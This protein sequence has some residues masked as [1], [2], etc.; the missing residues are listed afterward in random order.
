MVTTTTTTTAAF[1]TPVYGCGS[2]LLHGCAHLR[3]VTTFLP[4]AHVLHGCCVAV[5]YDHYSCRYVAGCCVAVVAFYRRGF[6]RCVTLRCYGCRTLPR[7]HVAGWL[8]WLGY[9]CGFCGSFLLRTFTTA[10]QLRLRCTPA[11]LLLDCVTVATFF[12]VTFTLR[13][14]ATP[15]WVGCYRL[16]HGPP[17]TTVLRL[18]SFILPHTFTTRGYV[19]YVLRTAVTTTL[20]HLHTFCCRTHTAPRT[21]HLPAFTCRLVGCSVAGCY[22]LRISCALLLPPA[23]VVAFDYTY[24]CYVAARCSCIFVLRFTLLPRWFVATVAFLRCRCRVSFATTLHAHGW[25]TL[26]SFGC[27][28]LDFAHG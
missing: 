18:D 4:V 24:L 5:G 21:A 1:C 8:H 17:H 10:L 25:F 15:F 26:R 12:Y 20:P 14:P 7:L 6:V 19:T 27:G 13:L 2:G 9:L 11:V 28:W 22:W 23:T 3:A 16:P